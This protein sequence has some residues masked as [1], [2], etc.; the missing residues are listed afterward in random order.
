MGQGYG[1]GPASVLPHPLVP[2]MGGRRP[3][4]ALGQL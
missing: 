3:E 2:A 4:A 1:P